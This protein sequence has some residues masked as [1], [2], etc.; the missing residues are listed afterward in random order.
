[1][2]HF[3]RRHMRKNEESWEVWLH[4]LTHSTQLYQF[5]NYCH[6]ANYERQLVLL[7]W[8]G[9]EGWRGRERGREACF[10]S[11]ST[12]FQDL[13][14]LDRRKSV[15]GF[16][17]NKASSRGSACHLIIWICSRWHGDALGS[18]RSNSS[19]GVEGLNEWMCPR[20]TCE[21]H[22]SWH[23]RW[24]RNFMAFFTY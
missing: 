15:G 8:Q 12:T 22:S 4:T 9:S 13:Q 19:S 5:N 2:T 7:T 18:Q 23:Q 3:I 17:G 21:F 1:M 14:K 10:F 20:A 16:L 24:M 6:R 11:S